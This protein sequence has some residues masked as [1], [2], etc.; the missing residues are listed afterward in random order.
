[1][2]LVEQ[3][4]ITFDT[5]VADYLP[6]LANLVIVDS[7]STTQTTFRPAKTVL[8]VKHLFNF[9]SG[10]FY[11]QDEDAARGSLHRGYYSKDVHVTKDPLT[12]WFDLLKVCRLTLVRTRKTDMNPI[13][14]EICQAFR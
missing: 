11:P 3:G 12:E 13:F 5:P 14:R 8:T 7:L 1:M 10:L 4:K 9:T 6:Q 2:K